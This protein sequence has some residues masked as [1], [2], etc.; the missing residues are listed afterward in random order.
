MTLELQLVLAHLPSS[1]QLAKS[2]GCASLLRR[3]SL[4]PGY[5]INWIASYSC[6][7]MKTMR[8][9]FL[10]LLRRLP[11]ST[12]V[13]T[14]SSTRSCGNLSASHSS[15]SDE[16]VYDDCFCCISDISRGFKCLHGFASQYLAKLCVPV[17]DVMGGRNLRSA[18]RGLLNF[19]RYNMTN[20]GRRSLS[21]A[22]PHAWNSL[23]VHL[24][25]TTPVDLFRRSLKTLL[26][27]LISRSAH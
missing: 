4:L 12:H 10:M 8:C 20:Y 3:L 6:T 13:S 19:P 26:F 1:R 9:W 21:H 14:P 2:P 11:T 17:A 16:R 27:G 23:P 18:T 5:R 25:Q 24:L 7:E 22:G 15:R